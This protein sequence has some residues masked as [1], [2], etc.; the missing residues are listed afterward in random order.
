MRTII[1]FDLPV[2]TKLQRKSYTQFRNFLLDEGFMMMQY[3][4]Y[5]RICNNHESAE[6][7]VARISKNLPQTGSIRSLIITEKQYERMT[8]L[9]GQK[10]PNEIKI[11]TN[12][13]SLF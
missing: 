1:F 4:V 2:K 12:Q 10:L 8:I 5:S 9:L 3:S 7:L 11:T 13:L 6:R